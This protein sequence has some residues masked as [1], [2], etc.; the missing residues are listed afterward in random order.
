MV[1]TITTTTLTNDGKLNEYVCVPEPTTSTPVVPGSELV[2]LGNPDEA[3]RQT[4]DQTVYIV[5]SH[6]I[7]PVDPGNPDETPRQTLDQT[8]YIVP[9]PSPSIPTKDPEPVVTSVVPTTTAA[10]QEHP[11]T[12]PNGQ[13]QPPWGITYSPFKGR[14]QC[15]TQDEMEADIDAIAAKGIKIIRL[16]GPDKDCKVLDFVVPRCKKHGIK[17]ILGIFADPTNPCK[18]DG[19]LN[20]ILDWADWDPVVLFVVGNEVLLNGQCTAGG[21]VTYVTEVKEKLRGKGYTGPVTIAEPLSSFESNKDVLCDALDVF[22]I[23]C[24]PYFNGKITAAGS[25]QFLMDQVK[26]AAEGK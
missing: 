23:H 9:V 3:P 13:L 7:P 8:V 14:G 5:P 12:P 19:D 20:L 1:P 26:I 4:L 15:R 18:A 10:V 21:V 17:I 2:G 25:G 16:Y 22:A 24:H 11:S 6:S